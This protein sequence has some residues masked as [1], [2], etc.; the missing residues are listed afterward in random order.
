MWRHPCTTFNSITMTELR[1]YCS[2]WPPTESYTV[3]AIL[4]GLQAALRRCAAA[5]PWAPV[6]PQRCPLRHHRWNSFCEDWAGEAHHQRRR[7]RRPNHAE[8]P[9]RGKARSHGCLSATLCW[10]DN[11]HSGLAATVI[12]AAFSHCADHSR[13]GL[14]VGHIAGFG[15]CGRRDLPVKRGIHRAEK[16]PGDQSHHGDHISLSEAADNTCL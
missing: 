15:V 16:W 2:V 9:S 12:H 6:L 4:L 5:A 7:V 11:I 14:D 10:V 13:E 3:V 8:K 1:I